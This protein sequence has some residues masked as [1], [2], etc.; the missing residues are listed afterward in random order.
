MSRREP[1]IYC[2]TIPHTGTHFIRDHLLAGHNT[3]VEHIWPESK[4]D[5]LPRL[6]QYASKGYPIVV[7]LRHPAEVA[8]SWKRRRK[9]PLELPTWW[10][11]LVDYVNPYDPFYLPL[12]GARRN[13]ALELL[14]DALG[15]EL[16]TDWEPRRGDQWAGDPVPLN[17][18][19]V[20]SVLEIAA[21]L[22][23]FFEPWYG[24]VG[25]IHERNLRARSA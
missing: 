7:P 21:E 19:E 22:A 23:W 14:S 8:L 4:F 10:R 5:W 9:D 11:T 3:H 15:A 24:L 2:P 20:D 12:D 16:V 1:L 25:S 13:G 17:A 6:T 18:R